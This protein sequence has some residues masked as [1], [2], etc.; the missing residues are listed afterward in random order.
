MDQSLEN[1][2]AHDQDQSPIACPRQSPKQAP[3]QTDLLKKFP[4]PKSEAL[5]EGLRKLKEI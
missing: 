4:L 2:I 1:N 3:I 5:L